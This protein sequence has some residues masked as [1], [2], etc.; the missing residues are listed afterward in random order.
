MIR[1][2]SLIIFCTLEKE[3]SIMPDQL[4]PICQDKIFHPITL[5]C[6]HSFCY[7]CIKGVY[8]RHGTCAMCRESIPDNCIIK[9]NAIIDSKAMIVT[10]EEHE[11][12]YHWMY[13]AK[14]GGWW[15]YEERISTE[16]EASFSTG[17]KEISIQISGYTYTVDF[18]HMV[19]Y[20]EEKPDR[21]RRIKRDLKDNER[22]KGVAGIPVISS[23][24][25]G[26][27]G[28]GAIDSSK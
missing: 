16:M 25:E 1:L 4:C 23:I 24:R 8:A 27:L 11:Q 12:L 9:P 5:P 17:K 2:T 15:L 3:D 14:N 18:E 13:E 6:G 20:R 21:R 22:V 7:L 26:P 10:T 28:D 19:Q